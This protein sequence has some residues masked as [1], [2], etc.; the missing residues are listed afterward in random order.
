MFIDRHRN[1][2]AI[3]AIAGLIFVAVASAQVDFVTAVTSTHPIAY[4]RLDSMEGNSQVGSTQYKS[5][6]GVTSARP[7]APIGIANN[8]FAQLDGHDGYIVTTQAGGVGAAAS[9]M[10]W[11]NMASLPSAERRFFYVAGESQNGN[12]LDLQFEDDNAL[13][14]YTASGGHLTYA[15]PPA[16]LVNHWHMIIAT[17]DTV[18]QT[19]VIY[20]DGKPVATDKGGGRAG[21]TGTF[22]IG[23]STVFTGRF[24]KGGI[25]EVGLWDRALK[26][27][28]VGSIYA[29]CKPTASPVSAS[30]SAPGTGP[31]ATT[32][33]VEVEDSS[34]PVALRR[35]EQ[36]AIMFLTAIQYIESDCQRRANRACTLD[37]LLAGPI[38][39]DGSHIDHLKFDPKKD[40]NYTY[41][42]AASGMAWEAHANAKKPGLSGFYFL[43][44]PFPATMIATYNPAGTAT[45]IDKDLT[46]RSIDGDSF[47]TR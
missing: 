32:A 33:K 10:A 40:I 12:D 3:S 26:A 30:P 11:V 19:R 39:A 6:G 14:F 42:L 31:F 5:S 29:A 17:V 45:A 9:M 16:T 2:V 7:G 38:A 34:G 41:T 46:G 15:P 28:E 8:Q 47:A 18:S 21:K 24:F 4:Y 20:W 44:K 22:S 27:A 37:Q 43:G 13:K 1:R 23:E 35:E 25:E 36:I